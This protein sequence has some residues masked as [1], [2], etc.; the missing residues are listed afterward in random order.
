MAE[1]GFQIDSIFL[2]H[3]YHA[4]RL[5]YS[6]EY[7]RERPRHGIIYVLEGSAVYELNDGSSF[8]AVK[9][10][11]LYMPK[12]ETYLTHCPEESFHHMTINFNM[13]GSLALPRRRHCESSEKTKAEISRIVSEWNSRTPNYR[14]RCTGLLYLLLC[15]QLD[16]NHRELS[17]KP[18]LSRAMEMLAEDYSQ[19]I[20]VAA[21]AESCGISETYFRK[22]FA[23][24][25][26]MSPM[27]YISNQRISYA[28]ELLTNTSI[29]VEN[30]G[31]QS[32]YRDPAYF[33]RIFKK[34]TGMSP[35]EYRAE[36]VSGSV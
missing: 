26:G 19:N 34:I 4:P 21:L 30:V 32:G 7:A 27:A 10:D 28:R 22:L 2:A 12:G 24:V 33:C 14:E 20:T 36:A 8:T 17:Q 5:W 15:S 3:K 9:D 31:Y 16:I 25:Y 13:H 1:S 6:S 11:I 29:S 35:S 23:R 18:L